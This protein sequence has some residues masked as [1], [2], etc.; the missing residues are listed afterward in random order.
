MDSEI[1]IIGASIIDILVRPAGAEVF[2]TGSSPA[3]NISM[4]FGGDALNEAMVLAHLGK[5]VQLQTVL[6]NDMQGDM[7]W[8]RCEELGIAFQVSCRKNDLRTGINVVLIQE[9]GE[10]SFLTDKN[11]SLRKLRV[12]DLNLQFP[13]STKIVCFASIF[14]FP[15]IGNSQMVQIFSAAKNQGKILC[16]DMT[17]CKNKE[18]VEDIREAL[19]YLDYLMPN[20]EEACLLTGCNHA[21]AAAD[22]LLAAGVGTVVIKCGSRGCLV[23]NSEERYQVPAVSR[24]KCVDTT[25]AGDNFAAGFV[26]GLSQGWNTRKCA[27]YANACAAKSVEWVGAVTW[28]EKGSF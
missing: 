25:G 14:V 3:E 27:E 26:Y 15:E 8:N 22:V 10:R 16:A 4:S 11:G 21:E 1:T 6:G 13:K 18:T 7:I 23:A 19:S 5:K 12:E 20:E 9:N 28:C 2:A 17:K 24:V